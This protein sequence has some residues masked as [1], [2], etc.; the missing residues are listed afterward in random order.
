VKG[1][2]PERRSQPDRLHHTR[3]VEQLIEQGR[4][5][6]RPLRTRWT[7]QAGA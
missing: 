7:G 1:H 6:L 4:G 2:E 5:R 3:M